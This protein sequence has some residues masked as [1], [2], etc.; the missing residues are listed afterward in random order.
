MKLRGFK[1]IAVSLAA[2]SAM[3]GGLALTAPATASAATGYEKPVLQVEQGDYSGKNVKVTITNPNKWGFLDPAPACTPTLL[4][5]EAG[6]K[7]LVAYNNSDYAGLVSVIAAN[8][9]FVGFPAV[10]SG[11]SGNDNSVST[12]WNVPNGVYVLAGVCGGTG[13]LAGDVGVAITPVIVPDGIGS[14]SP[15]LAFSSLMLESG[16]TI[17]S[18]LPLL[19]GLG[20]AGG[21]A[22]S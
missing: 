19:A 14:I 4:S 20:S 6:L 16:D 21:A 1:R 2:A 22:L 18:V 11:F 17:A 10:N 9:S 3:V 13:T 7:A 12:N 15:A 5:G 8:N